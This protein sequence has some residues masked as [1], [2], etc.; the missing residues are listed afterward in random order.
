[1][2]KSLLKQQELSLKEP[3]SL[4][5]KE[6]L[7]LALK[8]ALRLSLLE[9]QEPQTVQASLKAEPELGSELKLLQEMRK[10]SPCSV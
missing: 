7:T 6:Q 10:P 3:L 8:E 2:V 5:L 4:S 9:Q 1:M